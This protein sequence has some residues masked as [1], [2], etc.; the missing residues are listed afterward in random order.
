MSLLKLQ[1]VS[2]TYEDSKLPAIYKLNLEINHGESVLILGANGAGKST[3]LKIASG[4]MEESAGKLWGDFY[5][6]G[7]QVNFQTKH[8]PPLNDFFSHRVGK[9]LRENQ[10]ESSGKTVNQ[11]ISSLSEEISPGEKKSQK[12]LA[13]TILHTFQLS[14]LQHRHIDSLSRGEKDRVIVAIELARN[15]ELIL[16]DQFMLDFDLQGRKWFLSLL[17]TSLRNGKTLVMTDKNPLNLQSFI[18]RIILIGPEFDILKDGTPEA[19]LSDTAALVNTGIL[20]ERRQ[21]K[22]TKEKQDKKPDLLKHYI[23]NSLDKPE[24]HAPYE[25]LS[26]LIQQYKRSRG[27]NGEKS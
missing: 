24:I 19:V 3:F 15:P 23:E 12:M 21:R 25:Q 16:I 27:E 11:L 18:T 4:L 10:L 6:E 2:F 8:Q 17:E 5:I 26:N 20:P 22:R 9:L 1:R 13:N 14:H 7:T